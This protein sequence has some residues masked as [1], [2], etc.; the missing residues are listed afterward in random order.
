MNPLWGHLIGV[1]I[2]VLMMVFI[3]IWVWAWLPR[4]RTVFV[5]LAQIP[6]QDGGVPARPTAGDEDATR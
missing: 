6:M 3:G 4:H 2:V 5:R 1:V